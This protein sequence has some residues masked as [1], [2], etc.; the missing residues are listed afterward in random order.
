M[1]SMYS[2]T[3][4]NIFS[5]ALVLALT[6]PLMAQPAP[7]QART[8]AIYTFHL[9][10]GEA[11]PSSTFSGIILNNRAIVTSLRALIRPNGT[12][13]NGPLKPAPPVKIFALVRVGSK[14][15]I[16]NCKPVAP[17]TPGYPLIL[18]EMAKEDQDALAKLIPSKSPKLKPI[19]PDDPVNV[20]GVAAPL[21]VGRSTPSPKSVPK[22]LSRTVEVDVPE[23]ITPAKV[24]ASKIDS[25]FPSQFAGAGVWDENHT[26]RGILVR[27]A[28]TWHA[29]DVAS[30]AQHLT[31]PKAGKPPTPPVKMPPGI[32]ALM[33]QYKLRPVLSPHLV[34]FV[35]QDQADVI[36]ARIAGGDLKGAADD[37]NDIEHL[38]SGTLAEQLNYR[39]GLLAILQ[40]KYAVASKK[41][42]VAMQAKD[43]LVASRAARLSQV[44]AHHPAGIV[45]P[46]MELK[47]PAVLIKAINAL[48]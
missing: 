13:L 41:M 30:M 25:S 48:D 4:R 44:L 7:S 35:N 16:I 29:V 8:V 27:Y 23:E 46:G 5:L 47:T 28:S 36:M 12:T 1:I 21:L 3:L 45:K 39:H 10:D 9:A 32:L 22:P 31:L 19:E 18:L 34:D 24:P 14:W 15:R 17:K 6:A 37:L 40:G 26:L 20:V 11:V 43:K 42:G 2:S 38:T 33:H